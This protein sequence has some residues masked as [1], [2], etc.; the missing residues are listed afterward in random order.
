MVAATGG[1]VEPLVV[2]VTFHSSAVPPPPWIK[3]AG[4]RVT[5]MGFL[6]REGEEKDTPIFTVEMEGGKSSARKC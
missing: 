3:A 2:V 6:L 4:L 1:R 5:G